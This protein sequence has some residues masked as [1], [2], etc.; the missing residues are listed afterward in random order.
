M[1]GKARLPTVDSL[2]VGN[3]RRLVPTERSDRRLGRSAARVKGPRYPGASP[4]MTSLCQYG[5]IELDSL[6]DATR[7]QWKQP[8]RRRCGRIAVGRRAH[9]RLRHHQQIELCRGTLVDGSA[10]ERSCSAIAR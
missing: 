10:N 3:T 1:S 8:A 6:R 9:M 7:S 5:D 4:W 2:L